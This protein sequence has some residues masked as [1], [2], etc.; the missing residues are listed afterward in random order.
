MALRKGRK[1]K[2]SNGKNTGRIELTPGQMKKIA[3]YEL[4]FQEVIGEPGTEDIDV[5]CPHVYTYTLDDLTEAVRNLKK[6][7]PTVKDFGEFWFYPINR[8]EES[9]DLDRARGVLEDKDDTPEELKDY[10][11]LPVSDSTWFYDI[12]C[13]SPHPFLLNGWGLQRR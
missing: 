7:D 2:M 3:R 10:D 6:K 11:G 8:L 4:T 1:M 12:W 13:Q 5:V 9:F